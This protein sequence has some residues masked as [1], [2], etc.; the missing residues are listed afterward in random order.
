MP[1]KDKFKICIS[2]PFE[3]CERIYPIQQERVSEIIKQ[4]KKD[5]NVLKAI[6]FGSSVT[7]ACHI[8]S[9]IDIYFQLAKNKKVK[10]QN[11][12]YQIDTW[13]NFSVDKNLY[14]KIFETG[15]VVYD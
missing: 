15:V 2:K 1:P 5:S 4:I 6:I 8:D 9:D 11:V 3:N 10:L 14:S 13:T 12:D 7:N